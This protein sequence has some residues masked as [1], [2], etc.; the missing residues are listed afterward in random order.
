MT[1]IAHIHEISTAIEQTLA[2][3]R[4][5]MTDE[6]MARAA[7]LNLY[8]AGINQGKAESEKLV[9]TISENAA[10]AILSSKAALKAI[11]ELETS[12]ESR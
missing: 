2:T 3:L 11:H 9:Q 1:T 10:K 12:L 5:L 4:E 6:K 8:V 7:L